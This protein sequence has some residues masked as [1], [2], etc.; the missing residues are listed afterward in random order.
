MEGPRTRIVGTVGVVAPI[1]LP[2]IGSSVTASLSRAPR[3]LRASFEN[4]K[5]QAGHTQQ[6]DFLAS[7]TFTY[8]CLVV[9]LSNASTMTAAGAAA[10]TMPFRRGYGSGDGSAFQGSS[11]IPSR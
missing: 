1:T 8:L 9:P 11:E 2:K 6:L 4:C 3:T 10:E 7:G 5:P